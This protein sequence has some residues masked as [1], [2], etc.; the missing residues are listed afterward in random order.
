MKT[1]TVTYKHY[2][3]VEFNL[4]TGQTDYNLASNQSEF[5]AVFGTTLGRFPTQVSIRTNNTISVKLNATT[6]DAITITS[7]DVPFVIRG[8]EISNLFFTNSSGSTAAVKL[9]FQD[10]DN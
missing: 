2:E 5:L 3:N 1:N 4:S 6:Q 10:V 9:F 7:T 8:I